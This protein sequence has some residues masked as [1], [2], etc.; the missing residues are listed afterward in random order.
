M[1]EAL[2]KILVCPVTKSGLRL[3]SSEEFS[4]FRGLIRTQQPG[5]E[6]QVL[7]ALLI[8]NDEQIAYPVFGGIPVMLPDAGI[9][10]V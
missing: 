2:L 8:R 6:S 5:V 9:A 10:L 1:D 3:A 7:T 4:R